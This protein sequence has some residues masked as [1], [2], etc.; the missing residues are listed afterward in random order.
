MNIKLGNKN[1]IKNSNIGHQIN[2]SQ[3]QKKGFAEKHPILTIVVIPLTIGFFLLF[4]F[5]KDFA[6]WIEGFFK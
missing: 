4:S 3:E 2:S 5:W 1:K 6:V